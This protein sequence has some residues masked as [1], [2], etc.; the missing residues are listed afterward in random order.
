MDFR[1]LKDPKG[2]KD[3]LEF[4]DLKDLE[5]IR[6]LKEHKAHSLPVHWS[7]MF[8]HVLHDVVAVD[9]AAQP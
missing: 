4:K 8:Q 6:V 9:M 3:W 2:H 5:E 1:V 7:T